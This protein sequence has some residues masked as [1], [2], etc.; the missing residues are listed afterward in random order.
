MELV[1]IKNGKDSFKGL[2]IDKVEEGETEYTVAVTE[3]GGI[4]YCGNW[5][6]DKWH[7]LSEHAFHERF[8]VLARSTL[9]N[10]ENLKRIKQDL[11]SV[12]LLSF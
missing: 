4:W 3:H 8:P 10:P 9:D 1:T 7:F 12:G 11:D 6:K 5:V 2:V